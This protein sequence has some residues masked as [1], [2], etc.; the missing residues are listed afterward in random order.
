MPSTVIRES[1][2]KSRIYREYCCFGLGTLNLRVYVA[3]K[4]LCIHQVDNGKSSSAV[5][6]QC[7]DE[8]IISEVIIIVIHLKLQECL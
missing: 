7:Q 2:T 6:R 4:R 8:A 1:W 5:E 3:S